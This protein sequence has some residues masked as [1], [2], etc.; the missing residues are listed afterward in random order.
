MSAQCLLNTKTTIFTKSGMCVLQVQLRT[1]D[2]H[3]GV[4]TLK[5]TLEKHRKMHAEALARAEEQRHAQQHNMLEKLEHAKAGAAE[6]RNQAAEL[7]RNVEVQLCDSE[8]R[9]QQAEA[10]YH[11]VRRHRRVVWL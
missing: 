3:K 10:L 1:I 9:V 5:A 8:K 4:A 2:I 11:S 7:Q 6:A